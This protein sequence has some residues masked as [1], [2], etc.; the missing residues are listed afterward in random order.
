MSESL[1]A[2]KIV[3][4]RGPAA[5]DL[6]SQSGLARGE[7]LDRAVLGERHHQRGDCVTHLGAH[8][9]LG[10][11]APLDSVVHQRGR[12]QLLVDA[13]IVK[14]VATSRTWSIDSLWSVALRCEPCASVARA[15]VRWSNAA[16]PTHLGE[17]CATDQECWENYTTRAA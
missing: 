1:S 4:A 14:Q 17:R 3:I 6:G 13:G 7:R 15:Y 8:A 12:D 5:N 2:A 10:R 9:T 16:F 11:C